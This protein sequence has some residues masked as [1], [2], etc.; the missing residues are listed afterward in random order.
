MNRAVLSRTD[1]RVDRRLPASIEMLPRHISDL[2]SL[3]HRVPTGTRIYIPD[4]GTDTDD[5]LVAAARTVRELGFAAVPH[6]AARRLSSRG[7]LATRIRRLATEA[8][9]EDML[10]IGGSPREPQGPF[11]SAFDVLYTGLLV[12]HGIRRLGVAGHPEGSPDMS[13]DDQA[14]ALRRKLDYARQTGTELRIVT[15]FGFDGDAFG[16]WAKAL[17]EDGISVPVHIGVAGPARLATLV[18]YAIACGVGNSLDMLRK[19]GGGLMSL[20]RS[21]SPEMFAEPLERYILRAQTGVSYLHV[22]PFGGIEASVDWLRARGS[23]L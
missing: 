19:R 10:V 21:Q 16:Q 11:G 3:A 22:Y 5:A 9:V 23:W 20:A 14:L 18:K 4:L 12:D 2:S 17:H 13:R 15:Q 7:Q 8:G 6:I 1:G